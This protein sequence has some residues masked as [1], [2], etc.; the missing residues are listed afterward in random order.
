VLWLTVTVVFADRLKK[1]WKHVA[2]KSLTAAA[3]AAPTQP[4]QPDA[5][6]TLAVLPQPLHQ[7]LHQQLKQL[8]H[9]LLQQNHRPSSHLACTISRRARLV[10]LVC[11]E[12]LDN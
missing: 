2:T 10:W 8:Q 11:S 1:L 3:A 5:D 12:W 6:Q 7:L 9:Q 4:V